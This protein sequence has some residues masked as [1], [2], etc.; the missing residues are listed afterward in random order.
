MSQPVTAAMWSPVPSTAP[1][2]E[3]RRVAARLLHTGLPGVPVAGD[4]DEVLGF[5]SRTA[6]LRALAPEPSLDLWS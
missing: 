1:E 5:V 2:T 6:L 4:N 3:L